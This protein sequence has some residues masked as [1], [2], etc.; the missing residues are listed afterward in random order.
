MLSL[1]PHLRK[2]FDS[3]TDRLDCFC[4]Q[5][6]QLE[7]WFKGELLFV[8]DGWHKA[9]RI[10]DFDREIPVGG[11]KVD[12]RIDCEGSCHW[13]ELKYWLIGM[14]KGTSYTPNFYFTDRPGIRNDVSALQSL[15]STGCPWLLILTAA[16]PDTDAWECGVE[17]FNQLT[18]ANL[19][20]RT[21]PVDFPPSYFLGL[22]QIG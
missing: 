2:H 16:R 7:G 15:S 9:K 19:I 18:V 22:L 21:S 20:P 17:K 8:L 3:L 12:I 6:V 14:Q 13:V 5:G 1:M 11:K 4:S 10:S